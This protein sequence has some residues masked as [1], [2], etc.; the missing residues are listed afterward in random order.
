MKRDWDLIRDILTEVEQLD[1]DKRFQFSYEVKQNST[2]E[3]KRRRD[4]AA[5]LWKAGFIE[6]EDTGT[7]LFGP[8]LQAPELTWNGH[9]LLDTIRSKPIWEKIKAKATETGIEL[10]FDTVKKLGAW[11]LGQLLT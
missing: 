10:T 4:H 7:M 3:A 11:A 8:S 5:L 1:N 9:D 2:L 6:G